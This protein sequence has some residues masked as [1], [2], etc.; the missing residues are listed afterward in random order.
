MFECTE[1]LDYSKECVSTLDFVVTSIGPDM[2]ILF[3][4]LL[5]IVQSSDCFAKLRPEHWD[6]AGQVIITSLEATLGS[7]FD[8]VSRD[9]WMHV[10]NSIT[11][12]MIKV[13]RPSRRR[14][15]Q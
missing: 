15:I 4:Q 10:Y 3:T 1:F 6:M 2:D 7:K 12:S 14:S 9:S 5:E 11:S 8:K 13:L